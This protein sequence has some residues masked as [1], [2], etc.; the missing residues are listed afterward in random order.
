MT[1]MQRSAFRSLICK[2]VMTAERV[3]LTTGKLLSARSTALS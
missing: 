1:K 3:S 2:S